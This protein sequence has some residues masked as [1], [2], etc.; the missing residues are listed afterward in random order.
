M[1]SLKRYLTVVCL[2][3]ILLPCSLGVAAATPTPP[4]NIILMISDGLG[5]SAITAAREYYGSFALDEF[6]TG[7]IRTH[8]H[9]SAVTDSAAAATALATGVR[10][11]NR[12]IGLAPDK[13]PLRTIM[14]EAKARNMAT[15]LIVTTPV[16][17]ATPAA[18]VAHVQ[19]RKLMYDV[20]E[21]EANSGT[22]LLLGGGTMDWLPATK[23]GCRPD[24]QDL[25]SMLKQRGYHTAT[26]QNNTLQIPALPAIGLFSRDNMDYV[27]DR[28]ADSGPG[29]A[30]MTRQALVQLAKHQQGFILMV[31][32]S[33]ID[34]AA[35]DNDAAAMLEE[36]RAYDETARVVLDFAKRDGATLVISVS[37]HETGGMS[38]GRDRDNKSYYAWRPEVLRKVRA[39]STAIAKL[40]IAGADPVS[41]VLKYTGLPGLTVQ[42]QQELVQ[43][44]HAARETYKQSSG[45][46]SRWQ[47]GELQEKLKKPWKVSAVKQLRYW[48]SEKVSQHALVGWTTHGHTGTDINLYAYG[49]GYENFRGNF[50]I[51]Y[52]AK[53]VAELMDFKRI[54]AQIRKYQ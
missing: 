26:Y 46:S 52:I 23:G 18:F 28:R 35:H 47:A 40:I 39:S 16:T 19:H 13:T 49:P 53:A 14:Q 45:C 42:E 48:I 9:D 38:I 21:Q 31:E 36:I 25:L 24:K 30:E 10:T 1:T 15:A 6:F 41:T 33:R 4:R 54:S 43:L 27:I 3:L 44:S 7:T 29:L 51:T 22:D 17:H 37:D 8:S 11:R 32:G 2:F 12:V 5:P 20:A 50:P 34:H